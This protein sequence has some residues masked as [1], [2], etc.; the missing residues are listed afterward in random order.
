MKYCLSFDCFSTF[1]Q[2]NTSLSSRPT[3]RQ[4]AGGVRPTGPGQPARPRLSCAVRRW[5][6]CFQAEDWGRLGACGLE[7]SRAACAGWSAAGRR[8]ITAHPNHSL[9]SSRLRG[10][11]TTALSLSR[12]RGGDGARPVPG[13]GR[14]GHFPVSTSLCACAEPDVP[15]SPVRRGPGLGFPEGGDR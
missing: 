8:V 13:V 4:V 12:W 9:S 7:Q 10:R 1:E 14:L 5:P 3:Q 11:R 2:C 6:V 15:V